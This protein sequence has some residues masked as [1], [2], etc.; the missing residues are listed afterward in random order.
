MAVGLVSDSGAVLGE[1]ACEALGDDHDP[2]AVVG[3]IAQLVRMVLQS[4]S[5]SLRDISGVGICCPGLIASEAGVV[6]AAA[7]L[8]G[9]RE[10]PLVALVANSLGMKESLVIL[11]ND[12][13][14]ALLAELWVGAAKGKKDVVLLTLGTGI[15][16][17]VVCGGEL[18]R[19]CKGEAPELG[20]AILVPGGRPNNAT[21]VAGIWEMYASA[22]AVADRAA[23][24]LLPKNRRMYSSL[25]KVGQEALT[26]KDVFQHAARGDAYAQNVVEETAKFLAIGCINCARYYDPELIL[27]T[28]GMAAAGEQLLE[29]VRRQFELHHWSIAQVTLEFRMAAAPA[30]ACLIGAAYAARQALKFCGT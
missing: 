28:G 4:A 14:T 9:W 5:Y 15:G 10:V 24:G 25:C 11:E 13:N 19:G 27:F 1:V 3:R 22:S 17:G 18:L 30:H 7:N 12:G 8:R 23:E 6:K 21:G 20:H 16:A 2:A 29:P 26:C